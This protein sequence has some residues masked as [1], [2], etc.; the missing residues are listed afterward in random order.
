MT[1]GEKAISDRIA[2]E[3]REL[4]RVYEALGDTSSNTFER[5]TLQYVD[6]LMRGIRK[7]KDQRDLLREMEER[8][9]L[10]GVYDI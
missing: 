8:Q 2:Q 4:E 1:P 7:L 5:N 9:Y 10:Y 3:V 6:S